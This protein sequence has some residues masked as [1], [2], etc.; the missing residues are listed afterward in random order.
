M[1]RQRTSFIYPLYYNQIIIFGRQTFKLIRRCSSR[2]N[3]LDVLQLL[4]KT[5]LVAL[6]LATRF[7][8]VNTFLFLF[9]Y[10]YTIPQLCTK[11]N[12]DLILRNV[13][14]KWSKK[15]EKDAQWKI[16]KPEK[17]KYVMPKKFSISIFCSRLKT[18][19]C[20]VERFANVYFSH[21]PFVAFVRI[22]MGWCVWSWAYRL[23]LWEW[24][25]SEG[26]EGEGWWRGGML[27]LRLYKLR[28]DDL[29]KAL[30]GALNSL[31]CSMLW[32]TD[33]TDSIEEYYNLSQRVLGRY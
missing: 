3:R 30:K 16:W 9:P 1:K 21:S 4:P 26:V 7:L 8:F 20:S 11:N 19:V 17:K 23:L 2:S 6:L 24:S 28:Y 10:P 5:M 14:I 13:V 32:P 22:C 18:N 27:G 15:R 12:V 31:W 29:V 25:E 33:A